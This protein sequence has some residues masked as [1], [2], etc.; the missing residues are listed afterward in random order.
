MPATPI[1]LAVYDLKGKLIMSEQV[2]SRFAAV[3]VNASNGVYLFKVGNRNMVKAL[4]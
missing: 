4:R 2:S 1:T 3:K